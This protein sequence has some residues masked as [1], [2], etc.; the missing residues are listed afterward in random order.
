MRL[1]HWT[2][3]TVWGSSVRGSSVRGSAARGLTVEI[4]LREFDCEKFDCGGSTEKVQR[5]KFEYEGF[6]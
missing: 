3:R 1:E 6:D 2:V 4:R 5:W